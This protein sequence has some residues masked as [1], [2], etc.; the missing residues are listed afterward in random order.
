MMTRKRNF[1]MK[2][3]KCIEIHIVLQRYQSKQIET[4]IIV[5]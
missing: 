5:Y 1:F 4:K 3:N 2:L